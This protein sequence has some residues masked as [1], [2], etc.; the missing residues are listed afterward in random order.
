MPEIDVDSEAQKRFVLRDSRSLRRTQNPAIGG[1]RMNS[2]AGACD[3]QLSE[4]QLANEAT[5]PR[6]RNAVRRAWMWVVTYVAVEICFYI[7][8]EWRN[9]ILGVEDEYLFLSEA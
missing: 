3:E 7:Y 5:L 4:R 9:A 1:L 8:F 2:F 6:T